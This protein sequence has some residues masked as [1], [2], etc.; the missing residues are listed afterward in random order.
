MTN[1]T[2]TI[3]GQ[4]HD[5]TTFP[6]EVQNLVAALSKAEGQF[7]DAQFE[8]NKCGIFVE[9]LRAKAHELATKHLAPAETPI[10]G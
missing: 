8:L 2:I 10:E 4:E 7:Q 1:P 9:A 5:L 6:A 3:D